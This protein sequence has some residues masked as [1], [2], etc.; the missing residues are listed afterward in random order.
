MTNLAA[1]LDLGAYQQIP[2]E[3]LAMLD[4]DVLIVDSEGFAA[5]SLA[6]EALSHPI[7]AALARRMKVV[8]LPVAAVDLRRPGAGRRGSDARRRDRGGPGAGGDAIERARSS[9]PSAPYWPLAAALGGLRSSRP[10]PRWS[11]ATSISTFSRR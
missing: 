2:L 5:P 10:S 3:R 11:S 7:V 4:A 8:S 6:T 9:A 1:R